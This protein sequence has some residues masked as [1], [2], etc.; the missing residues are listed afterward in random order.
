MRYEYV[1]AKDSG[2]QVYSPLLERHYT[3]EPGDVI[4]VTGREPENEPHT[5]KVTIRGNKYL[6]RKWKLSYFKAM[7]EVPDVV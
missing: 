7:M 6:M 3:L 1:G 5:F 2:I 4:E